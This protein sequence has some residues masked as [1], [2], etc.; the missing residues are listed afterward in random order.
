MTI[1]PI[2]LKLPID[3]IE[4]TKL[5][6]KPVR[7]Y[8]M[9]KAVV[10]V[11]TNTEGGGRYVGSSL[12]LSNR[13]NSG[14]FR[15]NK[16]KRPIESA[17]KE[18]G[19]DNFTLDI[20]LLPTS[21]LESTDKLNLSNLVLAF[22][23]ILILLYNPEYIV[24]KV[25]GSSFG[26]VLTDEA[27]A[28]NLNHLKNLNSSDKQKE[29]LSKYNQLRKISVWIFDTVTCETTA[30]NSMSEAGQALGVSVNVVWWA[31]RVLKEKGVYRQ[32]NNRYIVV[33]KYYTS[34]DKELILEKLKHPIKIKDKQKV[35]VFYTATKETIVYSSANEAASAI[36]CDVR[37][38]NKSIKNL[39]EV[40]TPIKYGQ[41]LVKPIID[42]LDNKD[43]G[44]GNFKLTNRIG[45]RVEVFDLLKNATTVY[46]S[47]SD[48][49]RAIGCPYSTVTRAL[50]KLKEKGEH[51]P[52]NN[53]YQLKPIVY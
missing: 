43:K 52:I 13:L 17:I 39:E 20:Y 31:Y 28:V 11:F 25:A 32:F 12:F 35:E 15:V 33:E 23:Q 44:L 37:T 50:N 46:N 18:V 2:R 24:L 16:G 34:E 53:R 10:Y 51:K 1:E 22:E 14:Y 49:A 21:N 48:S 41:Y 5:L 27:K 40:Y 42:S 3:T 36:G 29:R 26:R 45:H 7:N 4:F 47:I 19:L 9:G 8:K 38:V 6:G 30:Y